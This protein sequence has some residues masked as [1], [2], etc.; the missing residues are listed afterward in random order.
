[1]PGTTERKETQQDHHQPPPFHQ[2][3]LLVGEGAG[4]YCPSSLPFCC[5]L[6][7]MKFPWFPVS[8]LWRSGEKQK[9]A[10]NHYEIMSVCYP[11]TKSR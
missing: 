5:L 3:K 6:C 9:I 11:N 10:L 7:P 2:Q 4:K 1:M 8:I